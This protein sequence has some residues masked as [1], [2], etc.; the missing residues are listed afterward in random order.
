LVDSE[1][2]EHP[3]IY[4]SEEARQNMYVLPAYSAETDR[5]VNR[6]WASFLTGN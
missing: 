6:L 5:L 1:I 3:G 2:L 4:P